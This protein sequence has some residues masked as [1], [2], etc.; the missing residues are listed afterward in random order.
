[1]LF[2]RLWVSASS[3]IPRSYLVL[4]LHLIILAVPTYFTHGHCT[5][6]MVI[7][8]SKS[9]EQPGL[10]SITSL[11]DRVSNS[12]DKDCLLHPPV[13]SVEHCTAA[14]HYSTHLDDRLERED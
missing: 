5:L 14:V 9:K 7:T 4:F 3:T 8:Y 2:P 6:C 1:M 10:S 13:R 12:E 11:P